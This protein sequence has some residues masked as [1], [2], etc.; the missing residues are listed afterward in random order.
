MI[1]VLA[2]CVTF[3]LVVTAGALGYVSGGYHFVDGQFIVEPGIVGFP[4]VPSLILLVAVGLATL[5]GPSLVVHAA[6]ARADATERRLQLLTWQLR[7]L[8]TTQRDRHDT[9]D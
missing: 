2:G 3:L 5:I 7:N 4:P 8:V 1:G 6:V 9:V